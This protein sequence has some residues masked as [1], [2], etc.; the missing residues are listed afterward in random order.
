MSRREF[1]KAVQR[2]ALERA[3][4]RCEGTLPNGERCPCALQIGRFH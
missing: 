3:D 4:G 1:T 2:S